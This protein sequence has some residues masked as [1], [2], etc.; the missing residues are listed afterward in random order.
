MAKDQK[1][2]LLSG[3]PLFSQLGKREL[4]RVG[5]L[6]DVLDFPAG[7]VLMRE[8]QSGA[9]A[10]IMVT[11]HADV[12]RGGQRIN[13]VG[14][15]AVVGEMALLTGQPRTAT[16]TLRTDAAVLV[17]ARREFQALMNEM[18]S[19]RAQVMES[20]AMRLISALDDPT[21]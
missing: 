6:T 9:E 20:L 19:V 1:L 15:G 14:P 3:V 18:P 17:L 12:E 21:L 8:G 10:M 7:R 11:G 4:E 13:E 16:V 5:Q 2:E